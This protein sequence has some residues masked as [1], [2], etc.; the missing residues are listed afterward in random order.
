M[1]DEGGSDEGSGDEEVSYELSS[2][3]EDS[4]EGNS[5]EEDSDEEGS[6]DRSSVVGEHEAYTTT[7]EEGNGDIGT[8][9]DGL[10]RRGKSS[11]TKDIRGS[12]PFLEKVQESDLPAV[13]SFE[14]ACSVAKTENVPTNKALAESDGF[15]AVDEKTHS[16]LHLLSGSHDSADF[17]KLR[18]LLAHH[19]DLEIRNHQDLTPLAIAIRSKNLR[20]MYALLISG[21]NIEAL[22]SHRQTYLLLA[23]HLGNEEAVWALLSAGADTSHKDDYGNTAEDLAAIIGRSDIVDL[24]SG[25]DNDDSCAES[26]YSEYST[27]ESL[28]EDLSN[29]EESDISDSGQLPPLSTPQDLAYRL[30]SSQSTSTF[31]E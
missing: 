22:L 29:G 9:R 5:D 31:G 26:H 17:G 23:C 18:L 4:Y 15:L 6:C 8:S 19:P 28:D 25:R 2:D 1:L 12:F 11:I 20:A 14:Y 16:Y 10:T 7:D 3:E 24:F 30:K 13:E 21:A 27:N